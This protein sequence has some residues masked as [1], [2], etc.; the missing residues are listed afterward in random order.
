MPVWFLQWSEYGDGTISFMVMLMGR[1]GNI[2]EEK[3]SM[4]AV[5]K[6][7]R[8]ALPLPARLEMSDFIAGHA[9]LMQEIHDARQIHLYLSI[10]D[11]AEVLT[12]P[13]IERLEALGKSLCVPV[14]SEGDLMTA[15][16]RKG[17]VLKPADYGQPEPESVTVIDETQI[18]VILMPLL[19]FDRR[20]YRLGY[21]KGFYDRF[22]QRLS[23]RG[24]FPLRLGLAFSMQMVEQVPIDTWDEPMHGVI[25][26]HG[27]VRFT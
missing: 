24:I 14:V 5:M 19:A 4:R 7:R 11:H 17:E 9:V 3:S 6:K 26:E 27:F 8:H 20:G 16:Y 10:E 1:Y 13:V 12:A 18:D 23:S 22:L 15:A 21:G 25:H 2:P